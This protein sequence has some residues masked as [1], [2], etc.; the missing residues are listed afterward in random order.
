MIFELG[1]PA[2]PA[3]RL[4]RLARPQKLSP[5]SNDSSRS[6]FCSL[7]LLGNGLICGDAIRS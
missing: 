1:Q 3:S 6:R 4:Q 7:V 2:C 5:A